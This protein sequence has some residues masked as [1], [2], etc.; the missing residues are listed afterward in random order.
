MAYTICSK[1]SGW[2]PDLA[3]RKLAAP[4]FIFI[5]LLSLQPHAIA[6]NEVPSSR[7]SS[8]ASSVP[9]TFAQQ[10]YM[11]PDQKLLFSTTDV[12]G[13]VFVHKV[14]RKRNSQYALVT[15]FDEGALRTRA[16]SGPASLEELRKWVNSS[17]KKEKYQG[18]EIKRLELPSGKPST[19]YIVGNKAFSS[20]AEAQAEIE[21][22]RAVIEAQGGDFETLA[23]AAEKLFMPPPE[24]PVSA[25]KLAQQEKE[26]QLILKYLDHLDVG[27][28]V[29]GPFQGVHT[30]E[31]ISWQS[32]GETTWRDTN[33]ESYNY[34]QQVGF[35][36]NRIV[37]KGIKAPF[38][39]I[40]PYVEATAAFDTSGVDFKSH[41]IFTI[42]AE[43]RPFARA[44]F[45]TN[46]RPWSLPLLDFVKS[47]R[48]YIAYSDRK[49]IKDEIDGSKDHDWLGGVSIFY[50]WGI[51]PPPI[52]E[53]AP[54]TIPDYIRRY[55]WGEYFG[56]YFFDHTGFSFEDDFNSFVFNSSVMLGVKLP[57]IP[58]PENSVIESIVLMPY[59]RYEH[60]NL[61]EFSYSFSNRHF[62]AAGVRWMPF[63]NYRFKD[64]EWLAKTKLFFEYVGVGKVQQWREDDLAPSAVNYDIRFGVNISS[65]RV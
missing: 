33:L 54:S 27:N 45:L 11:R 57:G 13:L 16:V 9:N 24:P 44:P 56:N 61:T 65:K 52:T 4:L 53:G 3:L 41:A 30:G 22:A 7:K 48:A 47:Y 37:F 18:A 15:D 62:V 63:N 23:D 34:M 58:V 51:D 28:E 17:L 32:F 25:R 20:A 21:Q 12:G 38:N 8:K 42:G 5:A 6:Q 49:N 29:F 59:M 10:F 50:E 35:W 1:S 2:K 43:W 39:T 40:D 36:T 64:N 14:D 31:P 26:E 19:L 60:V 55:I 46:F